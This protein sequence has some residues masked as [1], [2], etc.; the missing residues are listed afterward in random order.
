MITAKYIRPAWLNITPVLRI[1]RIHIGKVIHIRQEHIDLDDLVDIRSGGFED[2]GQVFNA[3]VLILSVYFRL[4]MTVIWRTHRV[5]L[6]ISIDNLSCLRVHGHC[7]RAV[8]NASG[9]NGLGVDTRQGL[10]GFIGQDGGFGRH[11]VYSLS[12]FDDCKI[13]T[14]KRAGEDRVSYLNNCLAG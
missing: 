13:E 12:N 1:N 3:L 2:M 14:R 10:G 7:A 8:D 4:T 6:D 9:D 11:C 5:S